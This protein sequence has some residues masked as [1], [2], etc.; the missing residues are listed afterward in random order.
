MIW[1]PVCKS[2]PQEWRLLI[3][4]WRVMDF[5]NIYF[6]KSWPS[7]DFPKAWNTNW[8]YQWR[9]KFNFLPFFLQ[10]A[11]AGNTGAGQELSQSG[12]CLEKFR[13]NPFV[14]CQGARGTCHFFSDKMSYWLT[15]IERRDMFTTPRSKTL[16]KEKGE[17]LKSVVS[18][19]QV[20]VRRRR[21]SAVTDGS[22][23]STPFFGDF[24]DSFFS[25][26]LRRA[27]KWTESDEYHK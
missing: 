14:E 12:S 6:L 8:F 9:L 22:D 21:G 11:G 15:T 25:F 20:C 17:D 24:D 23:E 5:P 26:R 4:L 1:T 13:P 10:V 19:C 7:R 18:K 2:Y 3:A 16:S 27:K